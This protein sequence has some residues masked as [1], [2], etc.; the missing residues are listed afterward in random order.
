MTVTDLI[1]P[2]FTY[3]DD[4]AMISRAGVQTP[5]TV[6]GSRPIT[7]DVGRIESGEELLVTYLLRVGAGVVQGVAGW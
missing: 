2:G 5:I 7:F 4:S 1:P 6:T 3:V